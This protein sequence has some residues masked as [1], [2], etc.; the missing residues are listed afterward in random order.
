MRVST[1]LGIQWMSPFGPIRIDY[2]FPLV[3][4]PWDKTENFRFGFGTRF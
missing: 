2:A 3:A 4:D 1:G